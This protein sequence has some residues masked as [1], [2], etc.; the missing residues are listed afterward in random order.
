MSVRTS[1]EGT[2]NRQLNPEAIADRT[3]VG[4]L[5]RQAARYGDRPLIHYPDGKGWKVDTWADLTRCTLA[6][7]SALVEAGVKA[8]DHVV[9]MGPNSLSWLYCDFGIQAAGAVSVPIYSGTVPEVA[10]VIAANCDAVLAIASDSN[11]ASKLTTTQTLRSIVTMDKEVAGWLAQTPQHLVEVFERLERVRPDD[12]CTIVYTSGTTGDPKGAE[13][14]HRNLV[15]VTRAVIKVH[16]LSESDYTLSW[17]PYSHVFER[18]NGT[19]TVLMFGGQTWL[20]GVDRLADDLT[21]VQP[22]ILLSVPRVYE[23]MHSRVMD[24]VREAPGFRRALFNW[25]VGVGTR[26]SHEANPGAMLKAEHG[27]AE[28]LVLG[29]LRDR[30][31][32]G[33][34]RFFISGGAALAREIE[35]FFWAIGVPILNGWGMTETSSGACS[36]TLTEHRFLTV[37]KPFPGIELRIEKDG[38]IL[39]NSP[40]N[41]LGYHKNPAAT[42]ETLDHGWIRTGDIG[43]IDADGFLKIT[44]R[45]KDLIKTAGGKY[46]APQ[47]LEFEIQRDDLVEQAVVIGESR[48]YVTALI[49]PD[50]GAVNRQVQGLPEDLVHDER[51]IGLIDKAVDGVN[52]RVGSWEAIK[53][54]TLL[55]RAFTEE[56]G[57]ITPTLKIKRKVVA[58]KYA[59]QIESMYERKK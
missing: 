43:E 42:A 10:Q 41:M 28:R 17:L 34:L 21:A 37:G 24:R 27:L 9:V 48:P 49:V 59:D 2:A 7:A 18:I 11:M 23:K 16:P 56:A 15:D 32:G 40:G 36:N 44:D 25:A 3:T 1:D 33:R 12:V 50:W 22:T 6:V 19:F 54:F 46:V 51:V 55:P 20:S 57:E 47:Q 4:V 35:E 30:L 52:K 58:Q 26:F 13:L 53:Y 31:V 39:V 45:K 5:F 29:P 14:A 8:G 38:E